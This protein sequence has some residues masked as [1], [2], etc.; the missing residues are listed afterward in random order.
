MLLNRKQAASRLGICTDTLLTLAGKG[1]IIGFKLGGQWRF[2]ERDINSFID[3]QRQQ[4]VHRAAV[5][6]TKKLK[7]PKVERGIIPVWLPG[8][9]VKDIGN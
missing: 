7:R 2:D 9:K 1:D 4:A 3:S 8:M 5:R 6:K